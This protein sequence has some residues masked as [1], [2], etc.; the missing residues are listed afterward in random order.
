MTG[1][2]LRAIRE[3]LGL[4]QYAFAERLKI[5]RVSV[6]RM[7]NG[8]QAITPSNALLVELV[9]EKIVRERE[10]GVDV[11]QPQRSR[12]HAPGKRAHAEAAKTAKG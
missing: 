9:A 3:G 10:A 4:G 6:T 2:E 8:N 5:N 1:K 12:G 11:A 7:E